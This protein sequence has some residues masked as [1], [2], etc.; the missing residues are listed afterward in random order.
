MDSVDILEKIIVYLDRKS[1]LNLMLVD[2]QSL[3]IVGQSNV[4]DLFL[5]HPIKYYNIPNVLYKKLC[6][7]LQDNPIC[8]NNIKLREYYKESYYRFRYD[9]LNLDG[10]LNLVDILNCEQKD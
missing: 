1:L 4:W 5:K 9:N 10:Y 8:P 2:W 3:Y 7:G 6:K